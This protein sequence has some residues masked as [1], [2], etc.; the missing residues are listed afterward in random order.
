MDP[1]KDQPIDNYY[2]IGSSTTS[3]LKEKDV[4]RRLVVRD[5]E[6]RGERYTPGKPRRI[7]IRARITHD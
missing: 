6:E 5:I 1:H 7:I 3:E 2:D 4:K